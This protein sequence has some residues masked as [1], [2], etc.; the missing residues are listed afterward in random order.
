MRLSILITK[1]S[2]KT[3]EL[4]LGTSHPRDCGGRNVHDS[5]GCFYSTM[6]P[7]QDAADEEP[8]S[9]QPDCNCD[10]SIEEFHSI[11]ISSLS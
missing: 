11:E 4:L 7:M 2:C 9:S 3:F 1:M 8:M 5:S 6:S 10:N